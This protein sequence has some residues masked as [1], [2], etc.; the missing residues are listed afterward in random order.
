MSRTRVFCLWKNPFRAITAIIKNEVLFVHLFP[1]MYLIPLFRILNRRIIFVEH[2]THNRRRT[3]LIFRLLDRL[4]YHAC[5]RVVC[6]S[7]LVRESLIDTYALTDRK[8]IVIRNGTS[9]PYRGKSDRAGRDDQKIFGTLGRLVDAKNYVKLIE[10]FGLLN[11]DSKLVIGGEGSQKTEL[12]NLV[13]K[14][15]LTDNVKLI[16]KVDNA[17]KFYSNLDFYIQPSIWEGY[18][19]TV[20]EAQAFRLPTSLSN[21]PA[22]K[23]FNFKSHQYFNPNNLDAIAEC[24]QLMLQ[25]PRAFQLSER[26]ARQFYSENTFE[27]TANEYE[28][29]TKSEKNQYTYTYK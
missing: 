5:E 13:K 20:V 18:G 9:V 12:E 29:L 6:V 4:V 26:A 27:G 21:I 16:G 19:L 15:K 11:N 10:A 14:L 28:K 3:R 23:S 1:S 17:E 8:L 2:S 25:N 24:I 22:F 7:N